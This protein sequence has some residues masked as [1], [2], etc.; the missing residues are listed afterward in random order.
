MHNP[1]LS[2]SG[3]SKTY[4][5][6]GKNFFAVDGVSFTLPKRQT[7]GLVGPSGSGKTTV[8]Q[9][10]MR[11]I[12]PTAGNVIFDG[13]DLLALKGEK[14]RLMRKNIQM[15]FQDPLASFNPRATVASALSDPLR[16]HSIV[17]PN[18]IRDQ[19]AQLLTRVGL[20]PD[21]LSRNITEISGGQ[22]QRVA[23]ARAIATQPK[24]IV[25]DE[26]VSALDV[27]IR[28]KILKLLVSIQQETGVSYLFISHDLAVIHAMA[29][30]T[31][32]MENGSIIEFGETTRLIANPQSATAQKL[33]AAAPQL[34][35]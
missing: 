29:H 17:P 1:I 24:L 16:I 4:S 11:L 10:I 23:I 7:L 32:I 18:H 27:S 34:L 31:A 19:S 15:V 35:A 3:L 12:E 26:S 2:V 13:T 20:T 33:V 28:E 21:Y 8:S 5:R 14:L 6:N 25:L 22:R 9:L 30:Q